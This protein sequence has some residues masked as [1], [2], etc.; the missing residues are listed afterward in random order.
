MP[1]MQFST[2]VFPAPLG[3]IRHSNSPARVSKETFCSTCRP[4]KA[5]PTPERRS[6]SAIP[7]AAAPVLLYVLV[8]ASL[9]VAGTQVELLNVLVAAQPLGGAVEHDAAV[10]DHV[11]IVGDFQRQRCVLLHQQQRHA[12]IP[13][14][15]LEP[16]EQL[17]DDQR[18]KA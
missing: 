2:E 4:P 15:R 14:D 10:L 7:A 13:A 6:C 17:L 16:A 9:P 11:S 5:R 8:A 1:Q 18:R 12:E 3:P